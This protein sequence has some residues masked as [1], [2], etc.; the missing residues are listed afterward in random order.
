MQNFRN[1]DFKRADLANVCFVGADLTGA[2]LE[3]CNV[4]GANFTNAV[5]R[6]ASLCDVD[7]STACFDGADLKGAYFDDSTV[8]PANFNPYDRGM[9]NLSDNGPSWDSYDCTESDSE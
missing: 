7:M 1:F 5:L 2:V 4:D 3:F 6:A 9:I 8:V